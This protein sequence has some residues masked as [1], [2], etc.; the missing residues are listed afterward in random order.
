M[1]DMHCSGCGFL[2]NRIDSIDGAMRV[3][4]TPPIKEVDELPNFTN[5]MEVNYVAESE[6]GEQTT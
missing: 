2:L 1:F 5:R 3:S 6:D 4:H